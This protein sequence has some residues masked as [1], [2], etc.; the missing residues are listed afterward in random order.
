VLR[1][2][3]AARLTRAFRPEDFAAVFADPDQ[4]S[5]FSRPMECVQPILTPRPAAPIGQPTSLT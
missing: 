3:Y 4:P 2:T 1:D 5:L